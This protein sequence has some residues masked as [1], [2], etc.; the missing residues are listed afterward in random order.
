[1]SRA[2]LGPRSI[3]IQPEKSLFSDFGRNVCLVSLLSD[4]CE[5]PPCDPWNDVDKSGVGMN[6]FAYTEKLSERLDFLH[7]IY[8]IRDIRDVIVSYFHYAQTPYYKEQFHYETLDEFYFEW[9]LVAHHR[10]AWVET[11]RLV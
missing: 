5:P 6:H 11:A 3:D 7:G 9:F 8:L 4:Y 10:G 1:L 2:P